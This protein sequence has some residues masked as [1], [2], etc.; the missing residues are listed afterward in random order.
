MGEVVSGA[1]AA[2]FFAL[3]LL[4]VRTGHGRG[5]TG[6]SQRLFFFRADSWHRPAVSSPLCAGPAR[7]SAQRPLLY[8]V[9]LNRVIP[10]VVSWLPRSAWEPGRFK[11]SLG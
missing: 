6:G 3:N 4:L 8:R 5:G 10:E 9:L 11:R 7:R 2:L 1:G